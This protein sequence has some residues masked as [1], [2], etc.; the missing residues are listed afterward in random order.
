[1]VTRPYFRCRSQ[2][3][4]ALNQN[5][6]AEPPNRAAHRLLGTIA[7]AIRRG[8]AV[9]ELRHLDDRLLRD[10]GLDRGDISGGA[11]PSRTTVAWDPATGSHLVAVPGP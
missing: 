5:W 6:R 8:L 2:K 3:S 4:R 11:G 7:N 1:M 9:R 10:I